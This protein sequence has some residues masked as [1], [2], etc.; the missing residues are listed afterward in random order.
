M[1]GYWPLDD[2][3]ISHL[4]MLDPLR[5]A[6]KELA[7]ACDRRNDAL[8]AS[9]ERELSNHF[10][11]AGADNFNAVHGIESFSYTNAK[12]WP[13]AFGKPSVSA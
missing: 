3:L 12:H 8:M 7:A 9:R 13:T 10:M 5:G 6:S 4:Q 11:S 1:A 2:S